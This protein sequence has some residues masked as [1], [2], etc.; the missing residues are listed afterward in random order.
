MWWDKGMQ[1]ILKFKNKD[2]KKISLIAEYNK[3][4]AETLCT[5]FGN[6]I[7]ANGINSNKQAVQN[8]NQ[9]W[10]CLYN[11]LIE[12]VKAILLTAKRLQNGIQWRKQGCGSPHVQG[13][14]E[15]GNIRWKCHLTAL[16][17]NLCELTHYAI[18]E[19]GNIDNIHTCFNQTMPNSRHEVNQWM[20]HTIPFKAYLQGIPDVTFHD[21]M[22]GLQDNWMD[23][24]VDMKDK[25]HKDIMQKAKA[26][27]DL[28]LKSAKW[29]TKSPDQEKIVALEAQL[30]EL[31]DLKLSTQLANKLNQ[32]QHQGQNQRKE[33]ANTDENLRNNHKN[34]KD[35]TN[36]H[37]QM[38]DEE[39]KKTPPKDNKPK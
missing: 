19:N 32:N 35:N 4:D 31:Q 28:L 2:G 38:K 20:M 39:W 36:K 24:T 33:G 14:C 15:V 1:R 37:L 17:A 7:Q 12:E 8:N 10:C 25:T 22:R 21:Y 16:W 23:Q 27:F 26:K 5:A 13:D 30:K 3:I 29:G 34:C 6:F 11:S 18:K 9:M